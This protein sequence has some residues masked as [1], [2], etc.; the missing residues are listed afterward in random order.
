MRKPLGCQSNWVE[1]KGLK[2]KFIFKW[3]NENLSMIFKSL[4]MKL[5]CVV[6]QQQCVDY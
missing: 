6:I 3:K 1:V 2:R 5:K 4:N